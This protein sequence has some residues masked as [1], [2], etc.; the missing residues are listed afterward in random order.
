MIGVVLRLFFLMQGGDRVGDKIHVHDVDLVLGAERQHRQA[1]Q[2]HERLHHV[3][4]RGLGMAAVAQ[5]DA[6]PKNGVRRIRQQLPHHVLA[7]FLGARVGIVVGAVPIDGAVFGDH[8]VAAL[9]RHRHRADLAEAA[10]AV[11]VL[12]CRASGSTSSVP[13][14]FTLRQ[15]FSDLRFSDAAQ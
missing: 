11:I 1:R 5:H 12:G 9:P 2:E 14:R 10:Q 15:L 7:K 6:G 4:L 13:R 8:F 3:E